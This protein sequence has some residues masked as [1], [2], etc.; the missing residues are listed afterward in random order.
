[1]K[2]Q[3]HTIKSRVTGAH[4][5]ILIL[6]GIVAIVAL[7]NIASVFFPSRMKASEAKDGVSYVQNL[8]AADTSSLEA[9][10]KVL[11]KN[12]RQEVLAD[13]SLNGEVSVWSMFDDIVLMG[14]SR[15]AGFWMNEFLDQSRVLAEFGDTIYKIREH[16][17][18]LVALN[19]SYLILQYGMDDRWDLFDDVDKFL[20]QYDEIIAEVQEL[21]PDTTIIVQSIIEAIDPAFKRTEKFRDLPAW[22]VAMKEHFTEEGIPYIDISDTVESFDGDPYKADG[23]HMRTEF[24]EPWAIRL[25]VE[26]D[27]L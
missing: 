3:Q 23:F 15:T 17:D 5:W 9:D 11:E 26:V 25:L 2:K 20:E 21:L 10:L 19:P 27:D 12:K 16:E 22:N 24:Y 7:V 14:E 4:Q 18:D 1:M 8:E 6:T 13:S